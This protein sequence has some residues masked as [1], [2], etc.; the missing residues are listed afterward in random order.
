MLSSVLA[1][2]A[3]V[4]TPLAYAV[5]CVLVFAEAAL[6]VGFVI[7]GE[8]AVLLG[9]A[10]AATGHLVLALVLV[11]VVVAGILGD[12]VGYEIG[13]RMGPRL[14]EVR[15]LRRH[16]DRL[17]SAR[18]YL[19][20]R[21]GRAVVLGRWTAFLRAVM[22]AMAGASSMSYRRFAVFNALGGLVWGVGVTLAGYFA[23]QSFQLVQQTLGGVG[24]A[25]LAVLAGALVW[26]WHR[27]RRRRAET[28]AASTPPGIDERL[29]PGLEPASVEG[30]EALGAQCGQ[31]DGGDVRGA[32][33]DEVTSDPAGRELGVEAP[34]RVDLDAERPVDASQ[35]LGGGRLHRREVGVVV[36]E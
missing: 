25:L 26:G 20:R 3:A 5:I 23:G 8:S 22:P 24:A 34:K 1:H 32:P 18:G 2:L 17:E 13:R 4:P 16:R 7:P 10:L 9:G 30:Q 27:R 21:G 33:V 6:F 29:G 19:R 15:L 14:L 35:Q 28:P 12:S 36:E 31:P 11:L